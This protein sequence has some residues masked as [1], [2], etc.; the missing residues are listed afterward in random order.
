MLS[1]RRWLSLAL[2]LFLLLLILDGCRL[3]HAGWLAYSN[4]MAGRQTLEQGWQAAKEGDWPRAQLAISQADQSFSVARDQS[5]ILA[6][7]P[8]W[9]KIGWYH[10]QTD[11]AY[12]LFKATEIACRTALDLFAQAEQWQ[13]NWP[14]GLAEAS[15]ENLTSSSTGQILSQMAGWQPLLLET[16]ANLNE[17]ESSL[18]QVNFSFGLT[19]LNQ[20]VEDLRQAL[21][22][23]KEL[24]AE[25]LPWLQLAPY[26][27]GQLNDGRFLLIL[28][29]NDELRPTGGFIGNY[30]LLELRDGQVANL[31]THDSYHLDMPAQAYFK[32]APPAELNKYLGVKQW[33]LRDANWSPDFPTTARQLEH[34]YKEQTKVIDKATTTERLDGVIAITPAIVEDLLGIVGPITIEDQTYNQQNFVELLQYRVEMSYDTYGVTSWDRKEVINQVITELE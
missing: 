20:P 9:S 2:G 15:L 30:G 28:Q 13:D 8:L 1:R 11:S 12:N 18:A 26:L 16:L 33:F 23:G 31:E 3:G 14:D 21:K 10:R 32:P 4:G 19:R 24:L 34:F 17:L 6:K 25:H 7:H 22:S 5:L 29:N 27:A